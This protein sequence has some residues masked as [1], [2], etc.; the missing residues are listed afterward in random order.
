MVLLGIDLLPYILNMTYI[1]FR[2][3]T[4]ENLQY[5]LHK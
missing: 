3:I 4:T 2:L 5:S 1:K